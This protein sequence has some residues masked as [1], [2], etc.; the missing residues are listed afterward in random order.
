LSEKRGLK[1]DHYS[2][3]IEGKEGSVVSI[4]GWVEDV[5]SIGPIVFMTLRDVRGVA[6]AVFRKGGMPKEE[7]ERVRSIPRQSYLVVRGEVKSSR[8]KVLPSEVHVKEYLLAGRALHPLPLDPTGRVEAGLDV[9]LDSRP[10]DL[11]IPKTRATFAIRAAFMRFARRMLEGRGFME[12]NTA[13]LIGAAAEGGAELFQLDYFGRPAFLAQS[14]QLYKEQLTLSLDRVYEIGTYFRAERMHTT[15]H[16]N[17][18]VSLDVEAALWDKWDAMKLLEELVSEGISSLEKE[19]RS[20]FEELGVRPST[21]ARP[22]PTFTYS[23][24][25]EEV[26][27]EGLKVEFGEDFDADALRVLGTKHKGYY[28]IIDWPTALKPFYIKPKEDDARFS[29]SFDLMY[30]SLE[31]ASGGERISERPTLEARLKE[32]GLKVESFADHLKAF[33]WGMPPHSGWG[34]GVDRFVAQVTQRGNIREAVLYPRDA[35]RLTP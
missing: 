21:P 11:R 28:F 31:L 22:F 27:A 19:A 1:R 15:R 10:L 16:L 33:D 32:K 29:E 12:V 26:R 14:P 17:E 2:D 34:F 18:F 3:E 5:R 35:F 13:K 4:A 6:Q 20:D 7:F 30:G 23:Q 25:L 24:A 9:R 8:S